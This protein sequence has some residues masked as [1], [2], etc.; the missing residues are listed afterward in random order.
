MKKSTELN[1]LIKRKLATAVLIMA[2]VVA[3]ATL[4][5]PGK[6]NQKTGLLSINKAANYSHKS[7]S[8]KS[9]FNY[10][11][12]N[13]FSIPERSKFIMLNTTIT[14]QKG[15]DTYILPLKKKVFLDKVKITPVTRN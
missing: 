6:K 7:F 8:L 9:G 14:Y 15:N 11:G 1:R 5:D 12:S 3:F 2:S 4:G 13:I 10:R